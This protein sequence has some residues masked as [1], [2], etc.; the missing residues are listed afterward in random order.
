MEAQ[1]W[2][3][4]TEAVSYNASTGLVQA[5]VAAPRIGLNPQILNPEPESEVI[6]APAA[7]AT[8]V[9]ESAPE[10]PAHE[11]LADV[12]M[13]DAEVHRH[14]RG[15]EPEP[16]PE[17]A[18]QL[19]PAL[20]STSRA[21]AAETAGELDRK[22]SALLSDSAQGSR[23]HVAKLTL[24]STL[25]KWL[26]EEVGIGGSEQRFFDPADMIQFAW[27]RQLEQ[28]PPEQIYETYVAAQTEDAKRTATSQLGITLGMVEA[29][30][31]PAPDLTAFAVVYGWVSIERPGKL[32]SDFKKYWAVLWREPAPLPTLAPTDT[33]GDGDG[34]GGDDDDDDGVRDPQL[35]VSQALGGV[36]VDSRFLK[37]RVHEKVRCD[38]CGMF[39][40]RGTRY[41]HAMQ[42]L[43]LCGLRTCFP[44]LPPSEQR[45]YQRINRP[46]DPPTAVEIERGTAGLALVLYD[47]DE[48]VAP[49]RVEL[50]PDNCTT[51]APPRTRRRG[52][53]H[54]LRVSI[55]LP[56]PCN[57]R[58]HILA[59]DNAAQ[60]RD[61]EVALCSGGL[62]ASVAGGLSREQAQRVVTQARA[63]QRRADY[64]LE[65]GLATDGLLPTLA[66]TPASAL[67]HNATKAGWVRRVGTL[68]TAARKWLVLWRQPHAVSHE[69][70]ALCL[71]TSD[72]SVTPEMVM[73]LAQ[74]PTTEDHDVLGE[75]HCTELNDGATLRV[76]APAVTVTEKTS[77]SSGRRQHG[78]DA[79]AS[80]RAKNPNLRVSK[81]TK[82]TLTLVADDRDDI[83]AWRM[84]I[85]PIMG[86]RWAAPPLE[87]TGI[88][89]LSPA[90]TS[91][92][93]VTPAKTP[94]KPVASMSPHVEGGVG[95]AVWAGSP[96]AAVA[97]PGG[98]DNVGEKLKR[99]LV[100]WMESAEACQSETV[101]S[102]VAE[103]EASRQGVRVLLV[104]TMEEALEKAA[105][106]KTAKSL[107]CV[108]A[109]AFLFGGADGEEDGQESA[110]SALCAEID[111]ATGAN[112]KSSR[113]A[114]HQQ[115][116][117]VINPDG[118]LTTPRPMRVL[119][120]HHIA[121][122]SSLNERRLRKHRE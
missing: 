21:T 27:R 84:A 110:Y 112:T 66:V 45:Y 97:L 65:R 122:I 102:A 90:L 80:D 68:S 1:G 59:F 20:S 7:A 101:L 82:T 98:T 8:P 43:D 26:E 106:T 4:H 33:D 14:V 95:L 73:Q 47:S 100:L 103:V 55:T 11:N 76:Q 37:L 85:G 56:A 108:V 48:S 49:N 54:C 36:A 41:T 92:V 39:P 64:Q 115:L 113:K 87:D 61:W 86:E 104:H 53:D 24:I 78:R 88:S 96:M 46:N 120:Y 99:R 22:R 5:P 50:L 28:L 6:Q 30:N 12:S 107:L 58:K 60:A 77:P 93:S 63:A 74:S 75:W 79:A 35:V 70:W 83:V 19:S 105:S 91:G 10:P 71:Y 9:E 114:V 119:L 67:D 94:L 42:D 44:A 121:E 40:I 57:S 15:T 31:V 52:Y 3:A 116:G 17:P 32:Y 38:G 25:E 23:E 81:T 2:S 118:D 117:D 16:E 72:S 29:G 13:P 62:T 34:E 111:R 69:P 51:V 89:V 18:L 109:N